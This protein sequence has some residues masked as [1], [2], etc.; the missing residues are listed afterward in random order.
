MACFLKIRMLV[1]LYKFAKINCSA[2][3]VKKITVLVPEVSLGIESDG[4]VL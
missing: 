2:K 1:C 4:F 3:I